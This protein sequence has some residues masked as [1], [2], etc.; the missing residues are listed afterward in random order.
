MNKQKLIKFPS[1]KAKYSPMRITILR[2]ES[3]NTF[4]AGSATKVLPTNPSGSIEEE[5][6]HEERQENFDW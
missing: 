6:E 1:R 4:A 3:E 5:W 2:I